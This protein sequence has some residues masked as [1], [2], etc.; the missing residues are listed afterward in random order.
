[1]GLIL[2]LLLLSFAVLGGQV[3]PKHKGVYN[4]QVDMRVRGS[5]SYS[6]PGLA[7]LRLRPS[8]E[9]RMKPFKRV[10]RV[11]KKIKK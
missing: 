11:Q 5:V 8:Y 9:Y 6:I 10:T 3:I 4:K 7:R 2:N 1:M